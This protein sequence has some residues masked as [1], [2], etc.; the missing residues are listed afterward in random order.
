MAN[1]K[2]IRE[3]CYD[4]KIS[5]KFLASELGITEHGLQLLMKNNQLLVNKNPGL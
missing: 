2:I 5:L 1:F 3:L 4:R